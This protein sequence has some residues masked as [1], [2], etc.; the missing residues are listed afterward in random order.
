MKKFMMVFV[1]TVITITTFTS[2]STTSTAVVSSVETD[3]DM[4]TTN[5]IDYTFIVTNGRPFYVDGIISYYFYNGIYYYP[6]V[7]NGVRCLH[8][9]RYVKPRGYVY[10]PPRGYRPDRRW[11]HRDDR[12]HFHHHPNVP[13]Y[14]RPNVYPNRGGSSRPNGSF[15]NGNRRPHHNPNRSIPN[16]RSSSRVNT[17]H[18]SAGSFI[19]SG[20]R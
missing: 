18:R 6:Y 7:Y 1:I 8:P 15:Y 12:H 3:D 4:Y 9:Y 10:V 19:R 20:R 17:S 2:C 11:I 13:H 5:T 16:V 14:Y